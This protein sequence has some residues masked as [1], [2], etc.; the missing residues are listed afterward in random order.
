MQGIVALLALLLGAGW[1]YA[2][3]VK[4]LKELAGK[5]PD[6]PELREDFLECVERRGE[7]S[8][9][10]RQR[11]NYNARYCVWPNQSDDGRKWK[12]NIGEQPFPWKG[13][14]DARVA[15]VDK[16]INED[17]SF[18]MVVADRMRLQV[19]GTESN[20]ASF[21]HRLTNL[22]RWQK[23]TQMEEWRRELRLCANIMLERGGAVMG[24][25]WDRQ[26]QLSY[27]YI[28][29]ETLQRMQFP[30]ELIADPRAEAIA[31]QALE[32]GYPGV[33]EA[34][35]RKVVRDLRENAS[36]KFARPYL[37]KD[38]PCVVALAPNED[39]FMPPEAT[40]IAS[41][42]SAFR[43][44]LLTETL[45]ME[46][47]LSNQWAKPWIDMMLETQKG[48][49][50]RDWDTRIIRANTRVNSAGIL[51]QDKL[52][53]VVHCWHRMH[54]A[55]GVPCLKYTVF[56]PNVTDKYALHTPLD[57]EHGQMPFVQFDRETR[58]RLPD[59]SRG[60]GEVAFTW[61]HQIKSQWDSRIDRASIA[62]LPPSHYP[63]GE[64]PDKWGPG[65][66]I[67]TTRPEDYGFLEVPKY[68][69]Q[70]L[71]VEESVRKFAD[72]YF[73]RVTSEENKVQADVMRQELANH[74]M[75][76]IRRVDTQILKLDQQYMPDEF[77]FRVVGTSKATPIHASR[78]DIQ[79]EFD[80]QVKYNI[81]DL[82]TEVVTAKIGLIEKALTMDTT[83][84][85]DRN[86]ALEV[87]F[88]LVDPDIGERILRPA[89]DAS[90]SEI[91]DEQS[92]FTKMM[93]G[94]DVDVKPEGQAYDL[95][96]QVLQNIFSTN[97]KA[98]EALQNDGRFRE[99][100]QKRVKQLQFQLQ[101]RQ[102]AIIGRLGA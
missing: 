10:R 12:A 67:P 70:S 99:L 68:D 81:G 97:P 79:G 62:T 63:P 11:L 93:A 56:N 59:D 6:L 46:R 64:A 31:I 102:N 60:Y 14:S 75:D 13:A 95:R 7:N 42:R 5:E 49:L 73:G 90:Q 39:F 52:F 18:L 74:F 50:S 8:V 58:S 78:E 98:N 22:L 17:V 84:R 82:D 24:V 15:L 29:M 27:E 53:E 9:F 76:C 54:D 19:S 86:G 33:S 3:A 51:N 37:F 35:L 77:Y 32:L 83:G 38:R 45:L 2:E 21:G 66:Q 44:E 25:F 20:D 87:V 28:D 80:V 36:A 26:T 16:Y 71:E 69:P 23:A 101:Q 47:R 48:R 40:D 34:T 4:K 85:V 91:D 94:L 89:M 65:V 57:Y 30:S 55:E 96:L 88:E 41:A 1:C 43:I 100:V 92:V 72:E 61:Q